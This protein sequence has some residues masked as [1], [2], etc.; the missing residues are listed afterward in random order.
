MLALRNDPP[1][2]S[3]APSTHSIVAGDCSSLMHVHSLF[4]ILPTNAVLS[5]LFNR[6][7]G[8]IVFAYTILRI[9][10][11]AAADSIRLLGSRR[12]GCRRAATSGMMARQE[13]IYGD[14][15]RTSPGGGLS[16]DGQANRAPR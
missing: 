1:S 12:K 2:R 4:A 6:V 15:G 3:R 13:S 14:G 5:E 11:V 9:D 7:R 16:Q 8:R 10:N